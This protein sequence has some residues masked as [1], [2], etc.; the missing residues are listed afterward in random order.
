MFY[1]MATKIK[2]DRH[3]KKKTTQNWSRKKGKEKLPRLSRYYVTLP[4]SKCR[5]SVRKS[6]K[7]SVMMLIIEDVLIP[8]HFPHTDK[9]SLGKNFLLYSLVG[10]RLSIALDALV[11]T[12]IKPP[13]LKNDWMCFLLFILRSKNCHPPLLPWLKVVVH[14]SVHPLLVFSLDVSIDN[15]SPRLST[16]IAEQK[17]WIKIIVISHMVYST[18]H[19][20]DWRCWY[21]TAAIELFCYHRYCMFL[22]SYCQLAPSAMFIGS[23]SCWHRCRNRD[24]ALSQPAGSAQNQIPSWHRS[25]GRRYRQSNVLCS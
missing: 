5:L 1:G 19:F 9:S 6:M 11:Q 20:C 21:E 2:H 22:P 7:Y 15:Q 3:N 4:D 10:V 13:A 18:F 8:L 12:E 23:C 14:L 17:F 16:L 24:Y 25:A